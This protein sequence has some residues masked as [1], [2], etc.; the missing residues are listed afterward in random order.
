MGN[1]AASASGGGEGSLG[2][3]KPS[4]WWGGVAVEQPVRVAL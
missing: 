4:G 3:T 1:Q 2:L